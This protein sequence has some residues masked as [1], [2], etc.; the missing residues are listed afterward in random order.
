M[1]MRS[2]S[3]ELNR[4]SSSRHR[5]PGFTLLELLVVV[6]ILAIL[7]ALL[8]QA[9]SS[10]MERAA[11][12]NC[13]ANLRALHVA[14]MNMVNDDGGELPLGHD[15]ANNNASWSWY[16]LNGDYLP[17]LPPAVS[18]KRRGKHPLVDPG[19]HVNTASYVV[20]D[21]GIN[22]H[23]TGPLG[24]QTTR[25][26]HV[27][28]ANPSRK[29]FIFCSGLYMLTRGQAESPSAPNLYLPG[30]SANESVGW[31]ELTQRDAVEGR[32]GGMIHTVT[33]AGNVERW[34]ADELPLTPDRWMRSN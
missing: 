5:A 25:M 20:G 15:A 6:A 26:R 9:A 29:F 10:M 27:G 14:M 7:I 28:I 23:L 24:A 18:G 16:L 33:V 2:L 4:T 13:V 1:S 17:P 30:R 31:P 8:F 11:S 12:T 32:H 3:I 19:S 34:P 22:R 21:Y